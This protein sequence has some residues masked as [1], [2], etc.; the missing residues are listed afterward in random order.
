MPHTP[1]DV[2][3]GCRGIFHGPERMLQQTI[4]CDGLSQSGSCG[5][6]TDRRAAV[7]LHSLGLTAPPRHGT[8]CALRS[9]AGAAAQDV[10]PGRRLS[11]TWGGE[12]E[13]DAL[14][15]S[16]HLLASGRSLSSVQN[17]SIGL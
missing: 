17:L 16:R 8:C 12:A 14:K 7:A 6:W 15:V 3:R 1:V 11:R 5:R 4:L 10:P 9:L 2:S 13:Q